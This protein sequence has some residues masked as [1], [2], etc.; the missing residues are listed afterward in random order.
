VPRLEEEPHAVVDEH[1]LLH[2]EAL[3]VVAAREPEDVALELVAEEIAGELQK[4]HTQIN[5]KNI[6]KT[7]Q[8]HHRKQKHHQ[9]KSAKKTPSNNKIKK[10]QHTKK[11]KKKKVINK[12][13]KSWGGEFFFFCWVSF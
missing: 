10:E 9:K 13:K 12:K 2:R 1:A 6:S 8:K 4:S 5:T 3:L 11:K 7:P